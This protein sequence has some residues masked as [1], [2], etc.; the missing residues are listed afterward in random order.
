MKHRVSDCRRLVWFITSELISIRGRL[1][2]YLCVYVVHAMVRRCFKLYLLRVNKL[3]RFVEAWVV[4][5]VCLD[6]RPRVRCWYQS[7]LSPAPKQPQLCRC[8]FKT[9]SFRP[10][11]F[12]EEVR[13][14]VAVTAL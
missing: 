13:V 8:L 10:Q 14:Y 5:D 1:L 9:L 6:A 4:G 12:W 2:A 7:P 3:G 11:Q